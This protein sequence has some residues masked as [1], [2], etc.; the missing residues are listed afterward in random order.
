MKESSLKSFYLL[1][2]IPERHL[3][4]KKNTCI[5][6][7]IYI[8]K[9]IYKLFMTAASETL[10]WFPTLECFF[11]HAHTSAKKYKAGAGLIKERRREEAARRR[12]SQL[13]HFRTKESK[14]TTSGQENG[15]TAAGT[16]A[17]SGAPALKLPDPLTLTS[18]QLIRSIGPLTFFVFFLNDDPPSSCF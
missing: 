10:P 16:A 15:T 17:G 2:C 4:E 5:Y 11:L 12:S 13:V 18:P 3:K 7:C 6:I 1:F 14:V 8:L 9:K